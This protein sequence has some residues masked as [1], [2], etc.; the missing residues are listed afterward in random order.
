[1]RQW[2]LGIEIVNGDCNRR[3]KLN[4]EIGNGVWTLKLLTDWKW[5]SEMDTRSS[6]WKLEFGN[7][8]WNWSLQIEIEHGD[9]RGSLE[10]DTGNGVWNWRLEVGD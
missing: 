4:L 3:P 6:D 7:R 1:M 5:R 8:D 2:R 10:T 9:W